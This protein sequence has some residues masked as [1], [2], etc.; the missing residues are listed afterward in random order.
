MKRFSST[1]DY[2]LITLIQGYV[3][4]LI[5]LLDPY[6]HKSHKYKFDLIWRG[7]RNPHCT[8]YYRRY[9]YAVIAASSC[10]P[11]VLLAAL[12]FEGVGVLYPLVLLWR[13]HGVF[14]RSREW[15]SLS[16]NNAVEQ[17]NCQVLAPPIGF[18]ALSLTRVGDLVET[19]VLGGVEHMT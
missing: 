14:F 19:T 12:F 8:K 17:G 9:E 18:V 11:R 7:V 10:F 1:R 5:C 4:A 6:K 13:E 16:L 2:N 3:F 15:Q